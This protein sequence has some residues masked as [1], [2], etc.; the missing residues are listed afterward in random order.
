VFQNP[1]P[2][3]YHIQCV[4][5]ALRDVIAFIQTAPADKHAVYSVRKSPQYE[6]QA[7]SPGTHYPYYPGFGC[8]L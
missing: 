6:F 3:Q 1:L 8:I 5:I 4:V 7:D 2:Q